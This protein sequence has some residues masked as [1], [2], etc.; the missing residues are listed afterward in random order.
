MS[1]CP[2]QGTPFWLVLGQSLFTGLE[3]GTAHR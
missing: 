1:R 2:R 3:G